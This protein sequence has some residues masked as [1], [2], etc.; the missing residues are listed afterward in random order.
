[1]HRISTKKRKKYEKKDENMAKVMI[2]LDLLTK[3]VMGAP[4]KAINDVASQGD[5]GYDEDKTKELNE[6]IRIL[7]NYLGVSYFTYQ[8]QGGNQGWNDR[9]RNRDWRDRENDRYCDLRDKETSYDRYIPPHDRVKEKELAQ[10]IQK[11]SNPKM[12]L[13]QF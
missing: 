6:E 7:S 11:N 8:R 10:R 12:C 13:L 1:M 9:D 5:K 4:T 3:H 2:Q